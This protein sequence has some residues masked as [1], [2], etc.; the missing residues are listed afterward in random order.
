M[1]Y[2][3]PITS[4]KYTINYN[5]IRFRILYFSLTLHVCI[6]YNIILFIALIILLTC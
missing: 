6:V 3:L 2:L 1:L 4:I 5:L